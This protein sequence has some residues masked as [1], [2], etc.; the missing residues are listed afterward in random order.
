MNRR[1]A[2]IATS[3][4]LAAATVPVGAAPLRRVVLVNA[5]YL[6][7]FYTLPDVS[8]AR[9][10]GAAKHDEHGEVSWL[11]VEYLEK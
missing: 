2:L 6:E 9:I 4:A 1:Q 3:A 11:E 7:W 5:D 10:L 8:D